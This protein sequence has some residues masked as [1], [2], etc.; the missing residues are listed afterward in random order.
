MATIFLAVGEAGCGSR[1][2]ARPAAGPIVENCRYWA[3][4]FLLV[5]DMNAPDVIV[6]GHPGSSRSPSIGHGYCRSRPAAGNVELDPWPVRTGASPTR[7]CGSPRPASP[8]LP[9]PGRTVTIGIVPHSARATGKA[10]ES[11]G[12]WMDRNHA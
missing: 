4:G 7:V 11:G 12:A 8:A 5:E 1:T 3:A 6:R 9:L 2:C 10:E